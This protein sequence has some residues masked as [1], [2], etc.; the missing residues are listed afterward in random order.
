MY[1]PL[2]SSLSFN[3]TIRMAEVSG[4]SNKQV[5]GQVPAHASNG[6][7]NGQEQEQEHGNKALALMVQPSIDYGEFD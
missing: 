7:G 5:A 6:N 1:S 4:G 3:E 2:S